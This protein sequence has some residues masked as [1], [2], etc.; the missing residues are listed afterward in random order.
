MKPKPKKE[1]RKSKTSLRRENLMAFRSIQHTA[2]Q[3]RDMGLCVI[4]YFKHN[5]MT[6][7]SEVHHVFGRGLEASDW[8]ED[9]TSQMCVCKACHPFGAARHAYGKQEWVVDILRKANATPIN[10]GVPPL[11]PRFESELYGKHPE[12]GDGSSARK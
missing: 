6:P 5:R 8:R 10:E 1:D 9:M 11:V 4:C 12:V 3:V 7:A 2:V